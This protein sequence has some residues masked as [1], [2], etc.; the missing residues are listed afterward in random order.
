M[1][2]FIGLGNMANAIIGGFI[3]NDIPEQ[4]YGYDVDFDKMQEIKNKYDINI[5]KSI[6]DVVKKSKYIFLAVKPNTYT[7]V[8]EEIKDNINDDSIIISMAAGI[9][10]NY[11]RNVLNFNRIVRIMPNTPALVGE[12]V[13]AASMVGLNDDEE[14]TVIK[15]LECIGTV[16]CVDESIINKFSAIS[17]SGPAFVALLIEAMVDAAVLI[18]MPRNQANDVVNKTFLGTVKLLTEKTAYIH[19]KGYGMLSWRYNYRRNKN[20]GGKRCSFRNY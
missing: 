13:V 3:K 20:Y 19:I 14:K 9:D 7:N 18:G 10:I 5:V 12:G 6:S 8:L 4:I 1:I 16:Y 11:I 15:M 17:G 2:G